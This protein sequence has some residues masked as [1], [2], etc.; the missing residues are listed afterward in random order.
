L[1]N[2]NRELLAS[3][4]GQN[5]VR[6]EFSQTAKKKVEVLNSDCMLCIE[7][8]LPDNHR[9][10]S[11]TVVARGELAFLCNTLHQRYAKLHELI[12]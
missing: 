10:L 7:E 3:T 5:P 9:L 12:W 11:S 4:N 8:T 2:I 1:S 6:K